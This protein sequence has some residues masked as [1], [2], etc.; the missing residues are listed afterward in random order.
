MILNK[1]MKGS[2]L[3]VWFSSISCSSPKK[4][5]PL[6]ASYILN[7][8]YCFGNWFKMMKISNSNNSAVILLIGSFMTLLI[9]YTELINAQY[10]FSPVT[11]RC[12]IGP[13]RI[14][15][16]CSVPV[17]FGYSSV[18][19]TKYNTSSNFKLINYGKGVSNFLFDVKSSSGY[20][21]GDYFTFIGT[22]PFT[23]AWAIQPAFYDLILTNKIWDETIDPNGFARFYTE[24]LLDPKLSQNTIYISTNDEDFTLNIAFTWD[25]TEKPTYTALLISE[26]TIFPYS[27]SIPSSAIWEGKAPVFIHMKCASH[28]PCNVR[29]GF[30]TDY[31]NSGTGIVAIILVLLGLCLCCA[32]CG[33]GCCCIVKVRRITMRG[34]AT[35]PAEKYQT[36]IVVGQQASPPQIVYNIIQAQYYHQK[37]HVDENQH[38]SVALEPTLNYII[39]P[40]SDSVVYHSNS[41]AVAN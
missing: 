30:N 33:I 4:M 8:M 9:Y 41:N 20:S 24:D 6:M 14:T 16:N 17:S 38:T 10:Y 31:S 39:P 2:S 7:N 15:F 25:E 3:E 40:N 28:N 11:P 23:I 37:P 34:I 1:V 18:P 26:S 19:N 27:L 36:V 13:Y 21:D 32:C 35:N 22:S 29:L 5:Q 12:F